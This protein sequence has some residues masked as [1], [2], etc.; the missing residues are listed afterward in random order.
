MPIVEPIG[1]HSCGDPRLARA[2]FAAASA[3]GT[4][5]SRDRAFNSPPPRLHHRYRLLCWSLRGGR[6]A[7]VVYR[8]IGGIVTEAKM[9][10]Y[11]KEDAG[12]KMVASPLRRESDPSK[13]LP[14]S[15]AGAPCEQ[16]GS[17]GKK[18]Y[19]SPPRCAGSPQSLARECRAK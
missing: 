5:L 15:S 9:E 1:I 13:L 14:R 18:E 8:G 12:F 19:A 16:L 6:R 11:Y 7:I 3:L 2:P 17:H 10:A 4:I